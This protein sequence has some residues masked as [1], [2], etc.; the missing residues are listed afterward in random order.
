MG[1][2]SLQELVSA[3]GLSKELFPG[4]ELALILDE[5]VDYSL[6]QWSSRLVRLGCC[7]GRKK[8]KQTIEYKDFST[9]GKVF[10]LVI[11]R[12]KKES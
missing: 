7:F 10:G 8:E 11:F 9:D 12:N 1:N 2:W 5:S 4:K 3:P 6:D